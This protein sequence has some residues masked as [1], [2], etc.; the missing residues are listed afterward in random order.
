MSTA[1]SQSCGFTASATAGPLT[2]FFWIVALVPPG[3]QFV[4]S[5]LLRLTTTL[6]AFGTALAMSTLMFPVHELAPKFVGSAKLPDGVKVPV[7]GITTGVIGPLM[8]SITVTVPDI[9]AV[10]L[11]AAVPN[12]G[13]EVRIASPASWSCSTSMCTPGCD[14]IVVVSSDAVV[15]VPPALQVERNAGGVKSS[16]V[17]VTARVGAPQIGSG[18]PAVWVVSETWRK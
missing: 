15:S 4:E 18:S 7:K 12:G 8:S 2:A 17:P 14:W 9:A 3:A 11:V 1:S 10:A 16:W 6:V 13:N 5:V